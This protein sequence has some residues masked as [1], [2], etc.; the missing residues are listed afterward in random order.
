MTLG[1]CHDTLAWSDRNQAVIQQ[2]VNE[3]ELRRTLSHLQQERA[4]GDSTCQAMIDKPLGWAALPV[5][6]PSGNRD[7]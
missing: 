5:S 3:D 1:P 2:G 6:N 7:F 4:L